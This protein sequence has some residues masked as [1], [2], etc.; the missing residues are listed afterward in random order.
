[1]AAIGSTSETEVS[2]AKSPSRAP[3][4]YEE[5]LV[6]EPLEEHKQSWI[7]LHGRG[8]E[9]HSFANGMMGFLGIPLPDGRGLQAHL[10]NVRFIFPTAAPRRARVFNRTKITQWF[11]VYSWN[12]TE[13]TDWQV[14]GLRETSEW[15]HELIRR[16]IDAVGAQNVV[17]GGLSQGCASSLISL[18]L[19]QGRSIKAVFGMSGWLPFKHVLDS[20]I[21]LTLNDTIADVFER[22]ERQTAED[23]AARQNLYGTAVKWL[24][25]ALD[26]DRV[27]TETLNKVPIFI[28]HGGRDQTVDTRCGQEAT[29]CLRKLGFDVNYQEYETLRHWMRSDELR[30][31]VDFVARC[32]VP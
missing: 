25:D 27:G 3:T 4:I 30:D 10:P 17:L 28:A 19:W 12:S 8:D 15:I 1:M 11:D 5:P 6:V 18:L 14:A 16:E 9:A 23:T 32:G 24:C 20:A 21:D 7:V 29:D 31:I 13:H 26:V 22:S 2:S